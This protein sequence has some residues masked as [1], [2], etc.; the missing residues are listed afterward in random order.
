M[1]DASVTIEA[2]Q[3]AQ[4]LAFRQFNDPEL[5][6]HAGL[7]VRMDTRF[8]EWFEP[9]RHADQ[10]ALAIARAGV[11]HFKEV[12]ESFEFYMR[13][14]RR[15]R[16]PVVV[17]A[18]CGHGLTGLL[19]AALERSVERVFLVDCDKP[20]SASA[21]VDAIAEEAPWIR[22]KVVWQETRLR[23]ADLPEDI[24]VV[25]VHACGA[26]TDRVLDL[27]TSRGAPVAVMPCC[28]HRTAEVVPP[29]LRGALGAE[30]ATDVH[31]TY[32]LE[33]LGYTVDWGAIPREITP[34]NRVL[35]GRPRRDA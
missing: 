27:A 18:C 23:R 6:R 9:R 29:A 32:G 30:L 4:F 3:T 15:V 19:F 22:D 13:T 1:R 20:A 2:H 33:G 7:R 28:Y 34:M 11:M 21:L 25:G 8:A 24:G 5:R 26:R 10:L 35:V 31:R 14:R 12:L 17:D 16:R